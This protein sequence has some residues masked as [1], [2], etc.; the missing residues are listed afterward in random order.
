MPKKT[1]S[2]NRRMAMK[3]LAEAGVPQRQT[4]RQLKISS[5]SVQYTLERLQKTVSLRNRKRAGRKKK[6]TERE[7]RLLVKRS[8]ADRRRTSFKLAAELNEGSNCPI[9]SNLGRRRFLAA[10]LRRYKAGKKLWVSQANMKKRYEWAK[11]HEGLTSED[12]ANVIWSH[13][14]NIQVNSYYTLYYKKIQTLTVWRS[15]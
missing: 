12:L 8:L 2:P 9:S 4:A 7:D 1:L 15:T 3:I 14:A 5:C 11:N 13:E 10:G 6:T